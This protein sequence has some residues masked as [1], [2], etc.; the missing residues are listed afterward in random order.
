[1]EKRILRFL[2]ILGGLFLLGWLVYQTTTIIIYVLLSMVVAL[3]GRPLMKLLDKVQIKGRQLPGAVK[4][5]I[6]LLAIFGILGGILSIFVPMIFAEAQLLTNI[7]LDKVKTALAPGLEWFNRMV[8]NVN[9]DPESKVS[10]NEIIQHVF[11]GLELNALPK[12]LNSIVGALGNMLIAVFSIAFMSFFFLKDQ[13]MMSGLSLALIP[14][15]KEKRVN[16]IMRNT[17]STLSRYFLGLLIQVVAI[18]ICVYIGLAIVGVE[19]A[20]LIAVFTGIV[21]LVPYLGPWIGASFGIFIVVANNLDASFAEVIQPKVLGL[22]IVFVS[23]QMIDNYI[24]Q[25]TIFSNS[26]NAHPLEIFIV[27][28]VAGSLGGVVGMIVAIPVYSFLRIVF[29]EMNKEF[30]WLHRIKKR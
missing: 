20:L 23:T 28:L 18:T 21:N 8:D 24:F 9:L 22:L 30:L 17:R 13:G 11:D 10:E 15:S 5:G 25:P 12:V 2:L 1:M 29:Q 16:N 26:I 7:D 4:A 27:I 6:T 14:T 3:I 19:N